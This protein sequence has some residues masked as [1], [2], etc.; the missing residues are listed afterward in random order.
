VVVALGDDHVAAVPAASLKISSASRVFFG[1]CNDLKQLV[2]NGEEGVFE[3]EPAD[4]RIAV[5][6]L[7]AQYVA[8]GFFYRS[9]F[10]RDETDLTKSQPHDVYLLIIVPFRAFLRPPKLRDFENKVERQ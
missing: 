6:D 4:A 10:F 5:T 2:A 7:Y 9:Q 3:S 8:Q 1:W